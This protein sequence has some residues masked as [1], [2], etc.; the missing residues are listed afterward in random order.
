VAY[1]IHRAI[2]HSQFVVFEHS[3]HLPFY[4]KPEAFVEIV[5]RFLAEG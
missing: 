2:P 5:E 4:E 3:G 1:Q